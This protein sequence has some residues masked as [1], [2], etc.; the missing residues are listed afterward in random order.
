MDFVPLLQYFHS[1][2]NWETIIWKFYLFRLLIT[3]YNFKERFAWREN[4][5]MFHFAAHIEESGRAQRKINSA[6]ITSHEISCSLRRCKNDC[7]SYRTRGWIGDLRKPLVVKM[8]IEWGQSHW[9]LIS[10]V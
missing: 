1:L 2:N 6:W 4:V 3:I 5:L 7:K 9:Q 10:S 8:L